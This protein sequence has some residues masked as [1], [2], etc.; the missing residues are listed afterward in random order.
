M[1]QHQQERRGTQWSCDSLRYC[2]A[3][4]RK[5][6]V[7]TQHQNLISDLQFK[8][9]NGHFSS[10]IPPWFQAKAVC[11]CHLSGATKSEQKFIMSKAHVQNNFNFLAYTE[12]TMD[13]GNA[14]AA[15]LKS[16]K[17]SFYQSKNEACWKLSTRYTCFDKQTIPDSALS[18]LDL[19]QALGGTAGKWSSN[20]NFQ[21]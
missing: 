18:V 16:I 3:A 21:N 1:R 9:C 7:R 13:V 11:Y 10:S 19:S 14:T 20:S 12:H 8:S 17:G 5:I 15:L 2:G 4:H 6:R